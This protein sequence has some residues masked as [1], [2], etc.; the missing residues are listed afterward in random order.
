MYNIKKTILSLCCLLAMSASAALAPQQNFSQDLLVPAWSLGHIIWEDSINT[1][2]GAQRLYA[3]Y[4]AHQ[5]PVDG[6]II[7]SPWSESY[8]D[9]NWDRQRYPHA[10]QMTKTFNDNGVKVIL[11]LTGCVNTVCK[12]TPKQK[13]ANYDEAYR[14]RYGINDNTPS[15]WWKGEGLMTDFTNPKA[16]E[17]WYT[18]L[19]KVFTDGVYGFKVD[20]GE[21]FFGDTVRTS[22]GPMTNREFRKYYY[23]AISDYVRMRKPE[24]ITIGRP[25]SHQGGF[26]STPEKMIVGWCGDFGGD[27]EGLKL[28]IDNVYRSAQ[29]GYGAVGCEVAGFMGAKATRLDFIRYAQFGAMT[30]CMI[31]G[32]E[33]GAFSSHLPWFHGDD[34][35]EIYR[36]CVV[37]HNQLRPYLFSVLVDAHLHGGGLLRRTSF[38]QESHLLGNDIFTKAIT[39]PEGQATFTLP[40]DGEWVDYFSGQSYPGGSQLTMTYPIDRFPLFVRKGAIIPMAKDGS[41]TYYVC[42]K[43]TTTR[44]LYLPTGDG[45]DYEE[46][47]V[48]YS[49]VDGQLTVKAP[50]G[51]VTE[52]K[53]RGTLLVGTTGD[54]RPLSFCEADGT[55]RGFGI[56]VAKEIANYLGVETDFVKTSWPTLTADV[57][58]EPQTFDLAIGGITITDARRETMLMSEGYLA[59][60][61]TILCR[62]SESDRYKSLADIDKPEVRV[63]VNP[64]GLNEKFANENLTHANIIVHQKNEEIPSLIAEGEADVMITEITEAPY[65]VQTDTRLA[66]PLLNDP[67]THG[68]IGVLMKK[69]QDDLMEMVNNAIRKMKSDG[70]L[71]RLHEKYGLVYAY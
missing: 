64:G 10:E 24:G 44:K 29:A 11:W 31:N 56:E 59:N 55:Y 28:Q 61:K 63:M 53:K 15:K 9:F 7:D 41:I 14:L 1:E 6:I 25:Y 67:F 32:G 69:G 70:T 5:I 16:R 54:Y 13:A 26:H 60:G 2:Q 43:G 71:R 27:W 47:D 22:V 12:D 35:S 51:K 62:A 48:T 3:E 65:Y 17:W 50:N 19:D 36:Q 66:A 34:V 30:A 18:Q 42:P 52:I 37:L 40:Q 33:N 46:C 4:A 21:I 49:E 38:E 20:Q 8:N 57:L 23:D 58:A 39:N 68:E 45:T